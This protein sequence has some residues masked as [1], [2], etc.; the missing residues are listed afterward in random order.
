MSKIERAMD[1]LEGE[2]DENG[3]NNKCHTHILHTT[4]CGAFSQKVF[5]AAV[6]KV[7]V[8]SPMMT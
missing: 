4:K 3:D 7:F 8:L 6:I 1:V 5:V 2:K